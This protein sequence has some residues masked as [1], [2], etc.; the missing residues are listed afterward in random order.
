MLRRQ[1]SDGV[2]LATL[3]CITWGTNLFHYAVFDGTFSH[4]Y[5]F[6]LV[7]LWVWL[8]E[9]WWERPTLARSLA[10][11][12]VAALNVLVRHTNAIFVL[13]LPLYGIVHWRDVRARALDLRDRWRMLAAAA[14]AGVL[15]LAPQLA[16]YKWITG[17]W[18]V[19]AYVT[20]GVGFT[21]G[22]P[23]LV[24]VLFSTQK[25]LFFW[26]PVLLL[27]VA[28]VFVATG[29]ARALALA[30]GRAVCDSDLA[31]RELVAVAVRR[32]LRPSRLH[33]RLR[34]R[35]AVHRRQLRLGGAPSKNHSRVRDRRD[36]GGAAVGRA[37][38]SV[39]DRRAAD[40]RHDVGAI[41]GSVSAIP[42]TTGRWM[43]AAAGL[44]AAIAVLG[45]LRPAVDGWRHIGAAAVGAGSAGHALP[46]DGRPRDV[47]RPVERRRA[48]TVPLRA[49]FPGPNGAPVTV[50]VRDDGRL[51]AT[52]E[53]S[54]P[55]VWVRTTGAAET[56]RG[57]PAVSPHRPARLARRPPFAARRDDGRGG[58]AMTLQKLRM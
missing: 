17:Q 35:R 25:G 52:I 9:Q 39:L 58:G 2:V 7:C 24:A 27:S 29:R 57:T 46:L 47:L 5:A 32:Q 54:D 13:L 55:D 42:M 43:K 12:A 4:A 37:D 56:L 21:F 45:Y 53:L 1:F 28:G 36:R 41:P 23:H 49:V 6:F 8:V 50:E 33:R 15:V 20:H 22:S 31:D 40:E 18:L 14:A 38:D 19:N 3:I 26:S 51:L 30:G 10:I 34:A 48:M 44:L 11:G 16:L